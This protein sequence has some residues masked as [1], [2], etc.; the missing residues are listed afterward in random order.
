MAEVYLQAPFSGPGIMVF[1]LGNCCRKSL[2]IKEG[3]AKLNFC[4][5]CQKK[6]YAAKYPNNALRGFA[7]FYENRNRKRWVGPDFIPGDK[8]WKKILPSI[9]MGNGDLFSV[10]LEEC[11]RNS[12][13]IEE[14]I[15]TFK[16]CTTCQARN[17]FVS[18]YDAD[19]RY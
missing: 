17:S 10:F 3:V 14:N 19:G 7:V 2:T 8:M 6:T 4:M 18:K 16:F 12:V 9:V 11:C 5:S 15:L 1:S 13:T